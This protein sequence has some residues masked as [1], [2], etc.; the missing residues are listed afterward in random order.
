MRTWS[1]TILLV[2]LL[3][4]ACG[5]KASQP[6]A[7]DCAATVDKAMSLS[8]EDYKKSNV[9]D[10]TLPKIR[11]SALQRCTE[12]KWSNDVHTCLSAAKS[13]DDVIKCQGK[14]T[15]EQQ[16]NLGKAI[17]AVMQAAQPQ[18]SDNGSADQGSGSDS[19][20]A[21]S[22]SSGEAPPAAGLPAECAEYK[23]MVEKLMT[24][25]KYPAASRDAM[26]KGFD[27]ASKAWDNFDKLPADAKKTMTEACKTAA[28]ALK[29]GA[30]GCAL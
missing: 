20:S 13:S 24:C 11:E 2:A 9:A 18:G 19:G 12:D 29:T 14:M 7:G 16:D 1:K 10:T 17:T 22:G 30:S 25:D 3:V 23:A 8:K 28:A 27:A 15:K 21:G 26:K 4:A 5:K 6:K